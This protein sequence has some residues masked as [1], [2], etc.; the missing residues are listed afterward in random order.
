MAPPN[1]IVAYDAATNTTPPQFSDFETQC[2]IWF[3]ARQA[4]PGLVKRYRVSTDMDAI[5]N[6][7]DA[8]LAQMCA[9]KGWTNFVNAIDR[10]GV[11]GQAPFPNQDLQSPIRS[12][13]RV[14][15]VAAG[16]KTIYEWINSAAEAVS[17]EQ[18]NKRAETCVNCP[19]NKTGSL[20]D[21]FEE[22]SAEAIK[23][24]LERRSGWKL[25]TP[26]DDKLGI[27]NEGCWC[28]NALSIHCPLD[29][30][31]KHMPKEAFDA[32]HESCWVRKESETT[33]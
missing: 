28:V 30:K 1:G 5:R 19:K 12:V 25:S 24:E 20:L 6:E 18:V 17:Q 33:K 11:S 21:F 26:F 15:G 23:R 13:S 9:D 14:A 2:R 31:L 10:V 4:N 16:V 8:Q 22:K 32:L 27:C 29:V 3:N 7:V